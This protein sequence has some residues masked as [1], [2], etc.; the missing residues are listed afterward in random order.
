MY[1]RTADTSVQVNLGEGK[2]G[3]P[4]NIILNNSLL[5]KKIHMFIIFVNRR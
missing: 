2:M 5:K 1:V 4:G 3:L